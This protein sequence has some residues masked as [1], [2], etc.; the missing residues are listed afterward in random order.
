M[1]RFSL[2]TYGVLPLA[3]LAAASNPALAQDPLKV[4]AAGSLTGP[5]TVL[6]KQFE[7][8]TGAPV[9]LVFGPS[10]LL[11]ERIE[12]GEPVDVFASANMAHPRQLAREG[13]ATPPLVFARNRV[14][15]LAR[16]E[17]QLNTENLLAKLLDPAVNIGTSTPKADPGGDYA[18]ILFAKAGKVQPGASELLEGKAQQLVG[19]KNSPPAPAGQDAAKYFLERKQV[20]AFIG[21]CSSRQTTHDARFTKVELPAELAVSA[22]FGL[23]VLNPRSG[24]HDTAYRFALFLL[25]PEAR[26]TL[27]DYGFSK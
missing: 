1:P 3:L 11:L 15:V 5:L 24:S 19:G 13:K 4:F 23:T 16:P 2:F 17:L 27:V 21:Y 7:A 6:A 18:W 10:G 26:Q 12:Q 22:D 25:T 20:D 8:D 14:C 9:E